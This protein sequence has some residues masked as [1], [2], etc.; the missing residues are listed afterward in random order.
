MRNLRV[1][2]KKKKRKSPVSKTKRMVDD[3]A[4]RKRLRDVV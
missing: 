2:P 1:D 3:G 4:S